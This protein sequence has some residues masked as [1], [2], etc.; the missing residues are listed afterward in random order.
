MPQSVWLSAGRGVRK[1]LGNAQMPGWV[2]GASLL[3]CILQYEHKK[4]RSTIF[5]HFSDLTQM[6]KVSKIDPKNTNP[7]GSI[8]GEH[9]EANLLVPWN[10]F[11]LLELLGAVRVSRAW[12]NMKVNISG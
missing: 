6:A 1:L 12:L 2:N 10:Q 8:L 4:V 3:P 11:M 9:L 5:R 7:T